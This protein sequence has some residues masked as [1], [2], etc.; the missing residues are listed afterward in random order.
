MQPDSSAAGII[1]NVVRNQRKERLTMA[2]HPVKALP[3]ANDALKGIGAKTIEI[4]HDKLYAGYV[5][6]RNEI[7]EELTKVDSS[8]ANQIYSQMRGLKHEET[9]AANGQILH[10]I[11]FDVMGG[12]GQPAG[13]VFDKI[14]EDFGSYATWRRTSRRRACAPAV[15]WFS[16]TI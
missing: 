9:F 5:N 6:K 13:E 7:E 16:R 1:H 14:K 8:K 10:E 12:D 4:H 15:G 11:Y 2:K 3:Y